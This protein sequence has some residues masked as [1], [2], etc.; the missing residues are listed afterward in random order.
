MA[1][2]DVVLG[3]ECLVERGEGRKAAGSGDLVNSLPVAVV[4]QELVGVVDAGV[5]D[6]LG[7]C[8]ACG[9]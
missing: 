5:A 9:M 2:W 6:E 4:G 3:A 8:G 1:G 7:G